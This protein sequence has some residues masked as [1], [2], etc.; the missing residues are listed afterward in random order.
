MR[1]TGTWRKSGVALLKFILARKKDLGNE[2]GIYLIWSMNRARRSL[3]TRNDYNPTLEIAPF[4]PCEPILSG[5][6]ELLEWPTTTM[7]ENITHVC[8]S[9]CNPNDPYIRGQ[10]GRF[11]PGWSSERLRSHVSG[12]I[13]LSSSG[14]CLVLW[15]ATPTWHRSKNQNMPCMI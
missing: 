10:I 9:I 14:W 6:L 5:L 15:G 11:G 1:F 8:Y 2:A 4:S 7:S 3:Q 13:K 12:G